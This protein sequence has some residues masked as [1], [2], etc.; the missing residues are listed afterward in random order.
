M[1]RDITPYGKQIK[2]RLIELNQSQGWLVD[3]VKSRTGLYFDARYLHKALTGK[4]VSSHII[5]AING[6]LNINGEEVQ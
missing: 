4:R 1:V 2:T 5:T 6:I 3:E